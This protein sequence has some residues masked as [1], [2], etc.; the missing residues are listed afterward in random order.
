M[1]AA[2]GLALSAA[3]LGLG[4]YGAIKNA[5]AAEQ[6]AEFQAN[7]MRLN[8]SFAEEQ[9][10]DALKRGELGVQQLQKQV[11]QLRGSQ[12]ASAAAQGIGIDTGS[13]EDIMNDTYQSMVDDMAMIR[14]NASREAYGFTVQ[15]MNYGQNAGMALSAGR[16]AAMGSLIGGIANTATGLGGTISSYMNYRSDLNRRENINSQG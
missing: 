1:A 3:G 8:Q 5:N 4:L 13:M 14:A 9:A 15:A 10:T 2:S 16:N 6:Q 12:R 11:A 7:Q